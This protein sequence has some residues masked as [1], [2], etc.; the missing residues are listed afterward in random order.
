MNPTLISPRA[1]NRHLGLALQACGADPAATDDGPT[2]ASVSRGVTARAGHPS[3]RDVDELPEALDAFLGKLSRTRLLRAEEERALARRV[4]RGDL[5]A[6]QRMIE[7]NLRLVVS[8]AKHYRGQGLP[9][10]D[11][12]QEGTI[13]LIRA[14]ELFDYRRGLK[15][16]TYATWWI[17]QAM[18]RSLAAKSR[19]VRLPIHVV[20]RLRKI[21]RAETHLETILG[22]SPTTDEIATHVGLPVTDVDRVRQASPTILSFQQPLSADQST[23]LGDLIADRE[24]RSPGAEAADAVARLQPL[25]ALLDPLQRQTLVLRRGLLGEQPHTL[26]ATAQTI[27]VSRKRVQEIELQ[28]FHKLQAGAEQEQLRAA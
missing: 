5:A 2:N 11:L 10:L 17:R 25:L 7:A 14:V 15:F 4:E 19:T 18:A 27:G 13:G 16:S 21:R 26:Q 23:T 24:T 12:I 28:A 9:F 1:P 20:D 3:Q 22:R 6:K 8:L